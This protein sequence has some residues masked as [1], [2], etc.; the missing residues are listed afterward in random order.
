MR[1]TYYGGLFDGLQPLFNR[2]QPPK[3]APY[4]AIADAVGHEA[5]KID[6]QSIAAETTDALLEA[7]SRGKAGRE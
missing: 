1:G 4:R 6:A 2:P 3:T 5:L 7:L